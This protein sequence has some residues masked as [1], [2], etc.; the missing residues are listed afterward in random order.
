MQIIVKGFS[1]FV[2]FLNYTVGQIAA[3][4]IYF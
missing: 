3:D 2:I 1:P 4:L